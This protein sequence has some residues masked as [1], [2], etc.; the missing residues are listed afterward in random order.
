MMCLG[1]FFC[2][3][4]SFLTLQLYLVIRA[5]TTLEMSGDF[6]PLWSERPTIRKPL[7]QEMVFFLYENRKI[8]FILVNTGEGFV[9]KNR[10]CSF[11]L[12]TKVYILKEEKVEQSPQTFKI[13]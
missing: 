6:D 1:V 5:E 3:Q 2:L 12:P 4:F 9:S 8:D 7:E 13:T 10:N 11:D